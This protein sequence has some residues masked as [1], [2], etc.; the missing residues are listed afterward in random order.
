MSI[1]KLSSS[2]GTV[3]DDDLL[4]AAVQGHAGKRAVGAVMEQP[5]ANGHV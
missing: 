5:P 3:R 2:L 1:V 4:D